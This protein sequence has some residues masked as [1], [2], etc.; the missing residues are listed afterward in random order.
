[1]IR[2]FF[3]E[4]LCGAGIIEG[5]TAIFAFI[6]PTVK[7]IF[8]S[9]MRQNTGATLYSNEWYITVRSYGFAGTL[10]DLFGMGVAI[11]AGIAFFYG[12]IKKRRYVYLG[13]LFS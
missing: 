1:M 10:V 2:I 11:I 4:V 7:N 6:S 3:I 12:V 9:V 5:F 13:S 8:V